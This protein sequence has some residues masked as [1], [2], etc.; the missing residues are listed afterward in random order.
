MKIIRLSAN[1]SSRDSSSSRNGRVTKVESESF[2]QR[3]ETF[4]VA[5][6]V[7]S[8]TRVSPTLLPGGSNQTQCR[9]QLDTALMF[10]QSCVA[11]ALNREDRWSWRSLHPST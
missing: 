8:L 7:K 5:T 11:H 9:P 4:F 2:V 10:I 1:G 3:L 6:R